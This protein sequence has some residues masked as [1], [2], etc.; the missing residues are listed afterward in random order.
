MHSQGQLL[1]QW[2]SSSRP[3]PTPLGTSSPVSASRQFTMVFRDLNSD[4][5]QH[6]YS[7]NSQPHRSAQGQ[8][9]EIKDTQDV[10]AHCT[11]H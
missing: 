4:P 9:L 3:L 6:L 11:L 2:P 8:I 1:K 10:L 7:L 5:C